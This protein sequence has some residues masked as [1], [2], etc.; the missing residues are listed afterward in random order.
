VLRTRVGYAGGTTPH[1]TYADIG[2]H[3]E[4]VEIEFDPARISYGDLLEV[5]WEDHDPCSG[6]YSRQY[7]ASVFHLDDAQRRLALATRD[8]VAASRRCR[9]TTEVVPA[10]VFTPAEGYHQKHYLRGERTLLEELRARYPD[11]QAFVASTAAARVNGYLGGYGTPGQLAAE[12]GGFGLTERGRRL[13]EEV[14][15]RN[16]P[17][18][19]CAIQSVPRP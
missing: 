4:T 5:F 8:R 7:Q 14:V 1:P 11:E 15:R 12:I 18:A 19:S 9:I 2:D 3:S 13:L 17:G 16:H 6:S 10:G